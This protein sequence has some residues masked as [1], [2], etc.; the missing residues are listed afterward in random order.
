MDKIVAFCLA[1]GVAHW[2]AL[3]HSLDSSP[4]QV[5]SNIKTRWPHVIIEAS[6]G[7]TTSTMHKYFSPHVDI[8]SQARIRYAA[9][10]L[11]HHVQLQKLPAGIFDSWI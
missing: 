7:I 1:M 11:V 10:L 4:A 9:L 2:G 5:A 8:I 6:G 3:Y